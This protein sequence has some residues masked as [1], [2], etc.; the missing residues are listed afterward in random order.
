MALIF[1]KIRIWSIDRLRRTAYGRRPYAEYHKRL[2]MYG[3]ILYRI[4][5]T[6]NHMWYDFI[7][8]MVSHIRYT[9]NG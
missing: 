8:H 1:N 9:V 3:T 4:P 7:P 5:Q 6:A 2:A